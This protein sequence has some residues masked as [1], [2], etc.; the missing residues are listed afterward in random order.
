MNIQIIMPKMGESLTEG[1]IL[2]WH[3]KTGE[4]IKKDEV[5]FEISTDKVDTEIT[6]QED[7]LVSAIYFQEGETVEVGKVLALL[8]VAGGAGTESASSSPKPQDVP[9]HKV[10]EQ[11]TPKDNSAPQA[12]I[13]IQMPKMGESIMEGTIIKWH[14]KVGDHVQKDEILF[15]ISTDKVDTE[16]PS[17]AEGTVLNILVAEQETVEVG[18][19]LALLGSATDQPQPAAT[20]NF[21]DAIARAVEESSLQ[22]EPLSVLSPDNEP[23]E[24]NASPTSDRFYSPLV[25]NIARK[26]NVSLAELEKIQGSGIGG[27]V[28]K[29]DILGFISTRKSA[30]NLPAAQSKLNNS[31]I[32]KSVVSEV[33]KSAPVS[34]PVPVGAEVLPMDNIRQKVMQHMIHS[35]D[36]SVHVSETVEVDMTRVS[37]FMQARKDE[38]LKKDGV[39]LTYLT[40]IA[41]AIVQALRDFPLVNASIDGNTIVKKPFVNLGIAVALEGNGLIVPNIKNAQDKNIVGL[42]KAIAEVA[43]KARTKKLAPDDISGGTFTITNY[44]VFGTLIG[45]PI[46]NQ[47]ELAI[48]GVGSV[49]KR[50][51]VV[52]ADGM[53]VIAIK[54]MMYLSL[55]H[56]HR[57]IDGMLGGKFLQAIVNYLENFNEKVFY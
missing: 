44:G 20:G 51:V 3:K 26:E 11:P 49:V 36:T 9:A 57:L 56:D 34:H 31:V 38:L 7:G 47:P 6:A 40:F 28:T 22:P 30:T 39:K 10:S 16:V 48:L 55:S 33:R 17:P 21:H 18:T 19:V 45:T 42:A 23:I 37:N 8:E 1:T 5:L 14:K 12:T 29:K 41:A 25:L 32:E 35:R 15:E 54:P 52:E 50:A 27:R 43:Q 4:R 2:K 46:I 24:V 53:D 13:E